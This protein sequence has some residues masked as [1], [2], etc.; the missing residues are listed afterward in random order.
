MRAGHGRRVVL[1]VEDEAFLR[2]GIVSEF[3]WQG[4]HV[5]EA[6]NGEQALAMAKDN[7]LDSIIT[8]INLGG[9]VSGWDVAEGV[10]QLWPDA[11]VVY[12]SGNPPDRSRLVQNGVFFDKPFDTEQVV[13]TCEQLC[14]GTT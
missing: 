1:V 9:R 10:R 8:D 12:T 6:A 7:R 11:V 4:W 2:A 3:N 5:L 13:H 14:S